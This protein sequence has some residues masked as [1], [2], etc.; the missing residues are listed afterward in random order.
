LF[1]T[2]TGLLFVYPLTYIS[3]S[4]T[5]TWWHLVLNTM[6]F[7]GPTFIKLGQWASTRRDLFSAEFC[8]FFSKLHND[9]QT[10]S[11]KLTKR[12]MKKAFGKNWKEIFVK[13]DKTPIGSGCIA[14]VHKGYMAADMIPDDALVWNSWASG[15]RMMTMNLRMTMMSFPSTNKRDAITEEEVLKAEESINDDDAPL[16]PVAIKV[17]HP[18]IGKRVKR[19]I[20]IL[21]LLTRFVSTVIPF[22]SWL[23][24]PECM[25]E[26]AILMTKQTDLRFEAKCLE[27]FDENFHDIPSVRFPRPIRPY[28][29]SDVLVETF[30][31]GEPISTFITDSSEDSESLREGIAICGVDAM[32]QMVFVDNFVH[33]DLHPGNILVQ[34]AD[35]FMQ[36]KDC[37][38]KLMLVDIGDTVLC[39]VKTPDNPL[40]LVL[41]DVGITSSLVNCDWNNLRKVFTALVLGEGEK[42]AELML[43][44]ARSNEC[45]DVEGFKR[46][47]AAIVMEA[48]STVSLNQIQVGKLLSDVF[49]TCGKHHIKMESNFLSTILAIFVLEGIGRSLYPDLDILERA[50][51]FIL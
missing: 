20:E 37:G 28:C 22:I 40:R 5:Q 23:S 21:R 36:N 12:K 13:L 38:N 11:W 9:S 16:I 6:E 35:A 47:L 31:E 3:P 7:T 29:K 24:L 30:E 45:S 48:R 46:E 51:P 17:L 39:D 42:V 19:D 26:F 15:P 18:H 25:E 27:E 2:F 33:G 50:K 10:H 1:L 34:N 41:L 14:Q 49:S 8:N 44:H 4:A 43:R 32:L